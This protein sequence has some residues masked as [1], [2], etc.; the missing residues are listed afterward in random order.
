MV[1][2]I[3]GGLRYGISK[4]KALVFSAWISKWL[5]DLSPLFF[6]VIWAFLID[7]SI[8][9]IK[10]NNLTFKS[11]LI[12]FLLYA[13]VEIVRLMCGRLQD[14]FETL[15]YDQLEEKVHTDILAKYSSLDIPSLEDSEVNRLFQAIRDSYDW[16]IRSLVF[17]VGSTLSAF[18]LIIISSI[19]LFKIY[20]LILLVTLVSTIPILIFN[21]K[22]SSVAWGIWHEDADK[23]RKFNLTKDFLLNKE[24][25]IE[26]NINNTAPYLINVI[27]E[28]LQSYHRKRIPVIKKR[29]L[30]MSLADLVKVAGAIGS[31]YLLIN[32]TL[33]GVISIGNLILASSI[34][35]SF[36]GNLGTL[37][38]NLSETTNSAPFMKD[39]LSFM[40]LKS[41]VE[42]GNI[43]IPQYVIPPK[44][45]FRNVSF[46]YPHTNRLILKDI[47]LTIEPGMKVALVGENGVGKTTLIKILSHFYNLN[48]GEILID[49]NNLQE[50]EKESW[51]KNLGLLTQHFNKYTAFNVEDNIY[52]GDVSR[53]FD[54]EKILK[55]AEKAQVT[56]FV[57]K[58]PKGFKQRLSIQFN[59]GID[60]SWGQWQR[61]GIARTLY[62]NSPIIILDEPTSAIDAQ[63]E[64]EIFQNLNEHTKGKTVVYVSHRYSTVR[65]ADLICVL[66]DGKII[67]QGKHSELIALNGEYAKNFRLQAEGYN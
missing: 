29:A 15:V 53:T 41:K 67:E 35:I 12:P 44:I 62:R 30:V 32:G 40:N 7:T 37:L 14:Y 59:D 64:Y 6:S 46:K 19:V 38:Y 10:N 27:K 49:G 5:Y 34:F 52:F 55:S 22:F 31:I 60:P 43:K 42:N 63:A 21:M 23:F 48:G 56:S 8:Q 45:E 13:L 47:D 3:I 51:E 9:G 33:K 39:F 24:N 65:N 20:P 36:S 50:I 28:I 17:T 57:N 61:I 26:V 11:L 66:K 18:L 58:Y 54:K 25:L 16:R 2:D 1:K 4:N